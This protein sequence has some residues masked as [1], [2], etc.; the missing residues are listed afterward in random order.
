M[1]PQHL[2]A[3]IAILKII[4][5]ARPLSKVTV[6]E[7]MVI[8]NMRTMLFGRKASSSGDVEMVLMLNENKGASGSQDQVTITISQAWVTT[9]SLTAHQLLSS[10]GWNR[11]LLSCGKLLEVPVRKGDLTLESY[12]RE[13]IQTTSLWF[14]SWSW[15]ILNPHAMLNFYLYTMFFELHLPTMHYLRFLGVI[16]IIGLIFVCE[17]NLQAIMWNMWN[18]LQ[19]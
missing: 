16:P 1:V 9:L 17:I 2:F 19:K 12:Q 8:C 13:T 15:K 18:M 6:R 3:M 14:T 4:G 11:Y 10:V 7:P 5:K